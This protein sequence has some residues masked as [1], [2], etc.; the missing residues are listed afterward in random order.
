MSLGIWDGST[1]Y[2]LAVSSSSATNYLQGRQNQYGALAGT[3]NTGTG[4]AL[5]KSLGVTPDETKS[6]LQSSIDINITYIIKY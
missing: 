3:T 1:G 6:G 5:G 2:A 4:I